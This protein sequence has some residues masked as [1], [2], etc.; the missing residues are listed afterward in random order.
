MRWRKIAGR[1]IAGE[2]RCRKISSRRGRRRGNDRGVGIGE[3]GNPADTVEYPALLMCAD[4]STNT[5][6]VKYKKISHVWRVISHP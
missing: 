3:G 4:S 1:R 6:N 2:R 5:K